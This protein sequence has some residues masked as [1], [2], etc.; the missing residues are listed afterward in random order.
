MPNK[1]KT[2]IMKINLKKMKSFVGKVKQFITFLRVFLDI[3]IIDFLKKP[4]LFFYFYFDFHFYF[5]LKVLVLMTD[6][7]QT[8]VPNIKDPQEIARD[9]IEDGIDILA[10]GI[11]EEIARI[12]LEA[13]ISKP[14]NL[15]LASN[16]DALV[17]QLVS[18]VTQA[19]TCD[20][21]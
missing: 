6:G 3:R 1:M 17:N 2:K 20:G 7:Q 16:F 15:F 18:E 4:C 9:L 8:Y 12:E 19:L 21:E 14:A 5:H 10:V 13:Y 11:G